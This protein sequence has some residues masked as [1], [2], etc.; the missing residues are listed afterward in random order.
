MRGSDADPVAGVRS[1]HVLGFVVAV[2]VV[3][4]PVVGVDVTRDAPTVG[5]G[6]ATV[7]VFGLAASEV[8][9][10]QGRFGTSVRYLRLDDVVVDVETLQG[11]PRLYYRLSIPNLSI[12]RTA[13]GVVTDTGRLRLQVADRAL[14]PDVASGTYQGRVMLR[15]DSFSGDRVLANRTFEVRV[16]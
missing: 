9:V 5:E 2:L 1:R 6:S 3:T 4:G 7:D 15:L 16:P 8:T 10:T 14:A 13:T 12:Q 11:Q